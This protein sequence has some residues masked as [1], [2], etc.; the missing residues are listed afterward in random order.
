MSPGLRVTTLESGNGVDMSRSTD[1]R[2]LLG[3]LAMVMHPHRRR[4][5]Q[6]PEIAFC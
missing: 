1:L 4:S 3:A 5:A 2:M 6:D